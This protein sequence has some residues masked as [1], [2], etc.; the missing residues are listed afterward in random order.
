MS[1]EINANQGD[2][3]SP[4]QVTEM[5]KLLEEFEDLFKEPT[6]L[7]PSRKFDHAI[8]VKEG[9]APAQSKFYRYPHSQKEE[10]EKERKN[11]LDG[12][13]I[14]YSC[15]QFPS[16]MILVKKQDRTWR[17]CVTPQLSTKNEANL[18]III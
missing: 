4:T 1:A 3:L 17:M 5:D 2:S 10:I 14:Q 16:P 9:Y 18:D 12:G 11:L 7:P 15:N 8:L 6:R 13:E